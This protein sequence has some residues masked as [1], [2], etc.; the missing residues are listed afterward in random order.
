MAEIRFQLQ[1]FEGK[2]HFF[3][4]APGEVAGL[5][6]GVNQAW[7]AESTDLITW[8]GDD[9]L[10]ESGFMRAV[11]L[12]GSR[13]AIAGAYGQLNLIDS[14]DKVTRR[15]RPGRLGL[16]VSMYGPN[17]IP[18]PGSIYRRD[19]VSEV[20]WLRED[21]PYSM[22]L[23]LFLRLRTWKAGLRY[24][25]AL[26]GSFRVHDGSLTFANKVATSV[27]AA[28]TRRSLTR[29]GIPLAEYLAA[30]VTRAYYLVNGLRD[31]GLVDRN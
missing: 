6:P 29:G 8:I 16:W 18:Q 3:K 11:R 17:L 14:E 23:D 27:E 28:E 26:T 9:D 20:G 30:V 31:R 2:V 4:E 12:L 22:D 15:L 1:E 25:P 24:V 21:L 5:A 10:L 7:A 19:A 13:P